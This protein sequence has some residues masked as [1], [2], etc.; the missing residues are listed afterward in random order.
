MKKCV[1]ATMETSMRSLQPFSSAATL[2]KR[3][4][5]P[6]LVE[7]ADIQLFTNT[8][9]LHHTDQCKSSIFNVKQLTCFKKTK[10]HTEKLRQVA[11]AARQN[12]N[13]QG[14]KEKNHTRGPGNKQEAGQQL[15]VIPIRWY[16][17]RKNYY[18]RCDVV[19]CV[20]A[21]GW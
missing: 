21:T 15:Y 13:N 10:K 20:C 9:S 12:A 1:T 6:L 8:G 19:S 4:H 3:K 18:R 16:H 14:R 11:S 2:K 17:T 5:R 7:N